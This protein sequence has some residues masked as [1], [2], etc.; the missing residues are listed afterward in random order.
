[1]VDR[2]AYV[3]WNAMMA[4]AFLQAGAVLD[5]PDCNALALQVLERIWAGAWDQERGMAH[6]LDGAGVRG[7]LDD[8]VHPA[9][10]FV[11]AFE[12]TGERRWL[13]RA[14]AV[15]RRARALFWDEAGGGFFDLAATGNGGPAYLATRA[16]PVQ[17]APTPSPN[18]VAGLVLARLAALTDDAEW[19]RLLDRL[20]QSFA[21]GAA[22]LSLY[23]ATLCRAIDWATQP[24]TRIEVT[25]PAGPGPACT[26][27]LLALQAYRPRKVVVRIIAPEARATVCVGT[28]CSLPVTTPDAL[29]PL[30]A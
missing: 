13:E 24:V 20:L 18:G 7:L 10:A 1:V 22:D 21:G 3:N 11:D 5:L 14:I 17:D 8:L 16:K 2:A 28:T 23:G 19:R 25:G 15:M 26:M 9:A 12:A 4:G 27:H 29:A 30:L 6:S